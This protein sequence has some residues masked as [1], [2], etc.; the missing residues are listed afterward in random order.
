MLNEAI[1]VYDT[2]TTA[3]Y[4][5]AFANNP[6]K[7][8]ILP[9]LESFLDSTPKGPLVDL[10]CGGGDEAVM[11]ESKGFTY[12]GIDL[13][14]EMVKICRERGIKAIVGDLGVLPFADNTFNAAISLW[15]LQYKPDINRVLEEWNRIIEP[16]GKLMLVVPHPIFKFVRYSGDYF[17][18]G[19]Q[20]ETGLDIKRFNYYYK[21]SDYINGLVGNGFCIEQVIEPQ[22]P[23]ETKR[24]RGIPKRNI[25][26]DLIIECKRQ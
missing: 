4:R 10:G 16:N 5:K 21:M 23:S 22:R 24:Y 13:S 11:V 12:T 6:S 14:S 26:H 20:W 15:A 1:D 17:I 25:P 7:R 19:I 2:Y 9:R 3:Q 8:L 18:E